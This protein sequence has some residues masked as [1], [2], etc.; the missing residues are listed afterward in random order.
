MFAWIAA[1]AALATLP[2]CP[3]ARWSIRPTIEPLDLPVAYDLEDIELVCADADGDRC[4]D[5]FAMSP[6]LKRVIVFG[7][8]R[9]AVIQ[10]RGEIALP[11][12]P[13]WLGVRDV[14]GDGT[15]DLVLLGSDRVTILVV[16]LDSQLRERGAPRRS[17]RRRSLG[18][19][20]R[21]IGSGRAGRNCW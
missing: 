12:R 6:A 20:S 9:D 2:A 11:F 3:A 17:R 18:S 14:D 5:V 1:L 16:F 4:D 15:L 13:A 10:P 19:C 7:G 21:R 8:N